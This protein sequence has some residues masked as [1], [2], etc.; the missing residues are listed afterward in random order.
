MILMVAQSYPLYVIEEWKANGFIFKVN[1]YPIIGWIEVSG[2]EAA[3]VLQPVIVL[4]HGALP[5][6]PETMFNKPD[7]WRISTTIPSN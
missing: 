7:A 1:A 2:F 5:Y 6:N 4:G 3:L